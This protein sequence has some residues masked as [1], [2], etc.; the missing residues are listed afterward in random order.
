M[1]RLLP[2]LLL[3]ALALPLGAA[4]PYLHGFDALAL[5]PPPPALHSA[6][7]DADRASALAV[8]KGRAPEDEARAKAEHKVTPWAFTAAVGHDFGPGRYP[9]L[10][11]LLQEAEAEAKPV[12]DAAKEHWKRPR[13]YQLDPAAFS[14]PAD[15]EASPGYP[16]GHSTRGTLLALIL[17]SVFPDHAVAIEAKGRLVGWTRVEIGAHTPLDIYAGRVLGQALAERMMADPAFQQDLAAARA[18]VL[19]GR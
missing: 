13:P 10:E 15:P 18:E 7:D 8:Y 19:A 17:A 2:P 11:A 6:E 16:S 14:R 4:G 9:R 5:L 3:L 12:V 1:R